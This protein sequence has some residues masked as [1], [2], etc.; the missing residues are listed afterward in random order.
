MN[1]YAEG[2]Y[3]VHEGDGRQIVIGNF[4]FFFFII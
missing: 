1:V 2:G 3:T 4:K